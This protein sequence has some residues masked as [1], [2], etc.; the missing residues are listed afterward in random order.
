MK[1]KKKK[2]NSKYEIGQPTQLLVVQIM[3]SVARMRLQYAMHSIES[4]KVNFCHTNGNGNYR[5]KK[6]KIVDFVCSVLPSTMCLVISAS[7]I[8]I[9]KLLFSLYC[10]IG[11]KSDRTK[12][13]PQI[14]AT[15]N[16]T[17]CNCC[18]TRTL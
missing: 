9:S 12:G 11:D 6:K 8:H 5:R 3:P 14:D 16:R 7:Y 1:A 18:H 2:N 13:P 15:I 4:T 17:I 10:P